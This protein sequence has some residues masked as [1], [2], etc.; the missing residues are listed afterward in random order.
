VL[1]TMACMLTHLH[2]PPYL[3]RLAS[4][5]PA[6]GMIVPKTKD[7]RVVFMLPWLDHTIAGT[8]D[9]SSDITMTPQVGAFPR[10][11]RGA[12]GVLQTGQ[13]GLRSGQAAA[14]CVN[15]SLRDGGHGGE[16]LSAPP[17]AG[18]WRRLTRPSQRCLPP[19]PVPP[20]SP[21]RTQ[22]PCPSCTFFLQPSEDEIQ[23]ILDAIADYLTVK[24]GGR[25]VWL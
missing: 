12:A 8:T 13:G 14:C 19:A 23:F 7:G 4:P 5:S 24:V 3:P 16:L 21:V 6:V 1:F 17:A 9:S 25:E 2:V 15:N 18:P 20:G 11:C 10:C 22:P